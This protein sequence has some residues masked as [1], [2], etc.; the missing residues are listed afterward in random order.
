MKEK[1]NIN[2]KTEV[3]RLGQKTIRC[4]KKQKCKILK[5]KKSMKK[6]CIQLIRDI[7]NVKK[8]KR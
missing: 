4:T 3:V 7:L 6:N 2:K 5:L 1:K 8:Q